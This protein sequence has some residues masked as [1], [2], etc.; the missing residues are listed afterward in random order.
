MKMKRIGGAPPL[1]P[2]TNGL[3]DSRGIMPGN[4]RPPMARKA[5]RMKSRRLFMVFG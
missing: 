4:E 5:F 2:G 3:A 1:P